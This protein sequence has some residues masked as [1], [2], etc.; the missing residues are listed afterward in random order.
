M[1]DEDIS[2]AIQ[3][4]R[5][6]KISDIVG[7]SSWLLKLFSQEIIDPLATVINSFFF[8]V[9]SEQLKIAKNITFCKKGDKKNVGN[10][11]HIALLPVFSK[12]FEKLFSLRII[13]YLKKCKIISS[14][15]FGYQRGK[16]TT[17]AIF[18]FINSIVE[19]LISKNIAHLVLG[20]SDSE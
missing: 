9:F 13:S 14:N 1:S 7:I 18:N 4:L 3:S 2:K 6:K 20:L 5:S 12:I 10:Y 11:R 8:E 17:D 15:Q 16:S 19:A